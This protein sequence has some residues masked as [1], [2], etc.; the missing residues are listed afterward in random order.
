[1]RKKTEIITAIAFLILSGCASDSSEPVLTETAPASAASV[2]TVIETET[3]TETTTELTEPVSSAAEETET[4]AVQTGLLSSADDIALSD[5]SG[6]GSCYSFEYGGMSFTANCQPDNWQIVDSYL[7]TNRND[8]VVIC[9]AL[10]DIQPIHGNDFKSYRTAED[11]ADEWVQH[12]LAYEMLP[13]GHR[14]KSRAKD[15]DFDPA[16]QGKSMYEMFISR[17]S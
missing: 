7:I 8:M 15:V 10:I 2:T 4:S 1:M 11:M 5:I 13:D 9:Q 14:W 17:T 12:N 16:D 6:D 3:V